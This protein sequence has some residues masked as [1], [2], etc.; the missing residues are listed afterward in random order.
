MKTFSPAYFRD[1]LA[2][3][4]DRLKVALLATLCGA[5]LGCASTSNPRQSGAPPAYSAS[6][7]LPDGV[8]DTPNN[9]GNPPADIG[10]FTVNWRDVRQVY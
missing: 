7:Y 8:A 5:S 9:T 3:A 10:P 2:K 1:A 6:T 4:P